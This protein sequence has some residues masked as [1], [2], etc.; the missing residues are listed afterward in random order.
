ML[1]K[2]KEHY[3]IILGVDPGLVNTGWGLVKIDNSNKLIYV[4]CGT[5]K[6]N[7]K[8]NIG[9]RLL[10]INQALQKVILE[11]QP[12]QCA[13]EDSFV[14]KNPLSSLKLGQARGVAML[15]ASLAKIEVFEYAPTLV[16]KSL[17]G[18]GRAQKEQIMMMVKQLLPKSQVNNEHEADALAIAICH[19]NHDKMN[20]FK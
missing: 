10:I 12:I 18:A 16:K 17:V 15:T 2:N 14:N 4:A 1:D 19:I 3:K 8:D 11:Y 20:K 7:S 5:I 9:N 6:T 13:I